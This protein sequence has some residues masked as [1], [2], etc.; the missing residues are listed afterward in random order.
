MKREIWVA[1]IL[2]LALSAFGQNAEKGEIPDEEYGIYTL[3]MEAMGGA[4]S[5]NGETL[6]GV[7][8]NYLLNFFEDPV[9]PAP[10]LVQDFDEKNKTPYNLSESFVRASKKESVGPLDG[11]KKATFSRVGFDLKKGQAL[12]IV[13]LTYVVPH[14]VMNEGKF[15][16]LHKMEGKWVV[17]KTLQA[18]DM[19]LGEI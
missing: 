1:G 5:V 15:V 13:G 3:A 17:E 11:K 14:D 18:W 4:S 16:L 10:D 19:R 8:K 6:Q 12:L 7:W 9:K 2:V